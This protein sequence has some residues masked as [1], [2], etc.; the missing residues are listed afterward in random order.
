MLFRSDAN[1]KTEPIGKIY[2]VGGPDV[3]SFRQLMELTLDH[4]ERKRALLS[5]PFAL[6]S[7]GAAFTG[8]LPN[9]PV[10]LD[11]LRLLRRDNVV[12]PGALG[13]ADLGIIATSAEAVLPT[14]LDR[15]R[16]GGLFRVS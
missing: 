13:L 1:L 6:M 5:I 16:P 10:T 2:E 4:I 12:S 14:Y 8:L 3:Y 11:Q 9:P 7:C 15:Y